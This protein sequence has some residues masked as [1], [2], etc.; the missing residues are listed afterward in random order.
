MSNRNRIKDFFWRHSAGIAFLVMVT[1][2]GFIG[3]P[4]DKAGS[5][6]LGPPTI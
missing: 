6:E 4:K 3:V 5:K 1:F 2:V